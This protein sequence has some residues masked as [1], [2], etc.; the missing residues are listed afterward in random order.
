MLQVGATGKE[1]EAGNMYSNHQA[2]KK[3]TVF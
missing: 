1:E 3:N 2:L